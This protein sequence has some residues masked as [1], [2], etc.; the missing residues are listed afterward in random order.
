MAT[1]SATGAWSNGTASSSDCQEAGPSHDSTTVE[2]TPHTQLARPPE[3]SDALAEA[4]D[5]MGDFIA[6][7]C[8]AHGCVGVEAIVLLQESVG[9]DD[10][11]HVLFDDR[12]KELSPGSQGGQVLFGL[13]LGLLAAQAQRDTLR[14]HSC[15]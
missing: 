2:D 6:V 3:I 7:Q 10:R 1:W 14:R 4:F 9:I 11:A 5:R 12:L 13:V 15:G 8:A